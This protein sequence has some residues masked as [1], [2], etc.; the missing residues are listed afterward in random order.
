V[1]G[2]QRN[3]TI[4][5]H[6]GFA[7]INRRG[8]SDEKVGFAFFKNTYASVQAIARGCWFESIQSRGDFASDSRNKYLSNTMIH[9]RSLQHCIKRVVWVPAAHQTL[10]LVSLGLGHYNTLMACE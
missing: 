10:L 7:L 3:R 6:T 9:S 4:P 1:Y 8:M 5:T 2:L